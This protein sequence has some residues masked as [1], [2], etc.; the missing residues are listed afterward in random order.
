MACI[1]SGWFCEVLNDF[2][3]FCSWAGEVAGQLRAWITLAEGTHIWFQELLLGGSQPPVT[4]VPGELLPFLGAP[5]SGYPTHR[6]LKIMKIQ[7]KKQ[8]TFPRKPFELDS[9]FC[10]GTVTV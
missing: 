4:L 5:T 7:I 9:F 1:S 8:Q 3:R 6:Q 2:K 10:N